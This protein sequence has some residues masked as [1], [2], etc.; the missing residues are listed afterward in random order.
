M[1]AERTPLAARTQAMASLAGAF[2]LG[3]VIGIIA[4]AHLINDQYA[5]QAV[6]VSNIEAVAEAITF[7]EAHDVDT[8]AATTVLAGGLA[9]STVLDHKAQRMI[10]RDFRPGGRIDLHHKDLGIVTA[11]ARDEGIEATFD[12]EQ[13]VFLIQNLRAPQVGESGAHRVGGIAAVVGPI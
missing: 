8:G 7:L 5:V 3:T 10:D 13:G 9:G 11:A 2:G 12:A 4:N 1:V 6:G